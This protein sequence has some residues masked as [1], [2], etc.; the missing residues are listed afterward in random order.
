MLSLV[1]AFSNAFFFGQSGGTVITV[2]VPTNG[3][4]KDI[5]SSTETRLYKRQD[6]GL[7]QAHDK[8]NLLEFFSVSPHLFSICC[9]IS[10]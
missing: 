5:V 10:Q 2:E 9:I 3:D 4:P 7:P 1:H 6:S 8:T